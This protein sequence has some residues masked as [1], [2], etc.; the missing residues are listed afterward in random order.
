MYAWLSLSL[1]ELRATTAT[2]V[3]EQLNLAQSR[4]FSGT[5]LTQLNAWRTQV[6]LLQQAFSE[7]SFDARLL[8]EYDLLRLE[9][10]IDAVLVTDRAIFVLEFKIGAE[11]FSSSDLR[12]VEDYAEDLH[13][14]HAASRH[15]PIIPLLI[16]SQMQPQLMQ[17]VLPFDVGTKIIACGGADFGEEI[18]RI[19]QSILA[20][21]IPIDID[22]WETA[23]YRPIPTVLEAATQLYRY[24]SVADI[25]AARA[26]ADNLGRTSDAIAEAIERA[27][28]E[29]SHLVIFVT[30]IPG[31][32]K[33]LCGL[34]VVF[35]ALRDHGAAFLSG[36]TPLVKVLREALALDAAPLGGGARKL[37]RRKAETALQN[38]HKFLEHHVIRPEEIPEARI[39]VFDEAQRAWDA[40]QATRDTQ[41]RV[42]RLT[43]SEP[44]HTLEIM[45]RFKDWSVIVA[46]IG[47]GQ[48]INTGE[49]GL[50]E[51]G[52]V[53]AANPAWKA[54]AAPRVIDAPD[55]TQRL[56]IGDPPW[57]R[58][59]ERLDLTVPMRGVR[60]HAGAAWVEAVIADDQPRA[61]SIAQEAGGISFFVTRDLAFARRKIRQLC[62]GFRRCGLIASA[63]AKR[64]RAEGL[65]V[66]LGEVEDWFLARWP[67][68]RSSE[69]LE[70]FATEYDCQGLEL[71]VVGL[72]WGGDLVRGNH[73]WQPREFK[74]TKWQMVHKEQDRRFVL[75][76]YRVLL[77]RARYETI[78]WVPG[79]SS[80]SDGFHDTTRPAKEMDRIAAFLIDC[81]AQLLEKSPIHA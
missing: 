49:A 5:E 21:P 68:I 9:K 62:R 76:S 32:G 52:R 24:N 30:G 33:T 14:F 48:E 10:R 63:G 44:A 51:W 12:Q 16:A 64:L 22:A 39:I 71:D 50:A 23:P 77:T 15:R 58:F 4:R 26:D 47:N 25:A 80:G 3:T 46:L 81:G 53:I 27:Q 36:N 69:A 75:N 41:R 19:Y 55:A 70:T 74:G 54:I 7:T 42:S 57:L 1:A 40:A 6:I 67:D 20:P 78:I 11:K 61:A 8:L 73:G 34:N 13:D 37:A 56:T 2:R 28:S 31:A 29:H 17:S 72:A 60:D 18:T 59:D 79:G 38:V 65:G 35:G 66:Q 45:G 43:N